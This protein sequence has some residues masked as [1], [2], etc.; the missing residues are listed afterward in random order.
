MKTQ[1]KIK[2]FKLIKEEFLFAENKENYI[3][4]LRSWHYRHY[5]LFRELIISSVAYKTYNKKMINL[6]NLVRLHCLKA[7]SILIEFFLEEVYYY[8]IS[9]KMINFS[10]KIA[11]SL[12]QDIF[13]KIARNLILNKIQKKDYF[14]KYSS[15]L[16]KNQQY[17]IMLI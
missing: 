12:D 4:D 2:Q 8:Q 5:P 11:E 17:L 16:F 3:L 7:Y 9:N 1:I 6:F 15:K 14:L 10:I 13:N